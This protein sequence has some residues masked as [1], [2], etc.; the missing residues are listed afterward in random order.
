MRKIAGATGIPTPF[1]KVKDN[2][3]DTFQFETPDD[4][5]S[6]KVPANAANTQPGP[7][8]RKRGN[9]NNNNNDDKRNRKRRKLPKGSCKYCPEATSHY[10]SECYM[11]IREQMGLPNGWQWCLVH[12]KGIHYEHKCRR[13]APDFPPV[14]RITKA[15]FCTPCPDQDLKQR[16]LTMLGISTQ[17]QQPLQQQQPMGR[18][19]IRITPASNNS[20]NFR[21][22]RNVSANVATKGPQ[23][24]QVLSSI[25]QMNETQRQSLLEGLT[26]AGF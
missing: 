8:R 9:N 11:T 7:Q 19:P 25:M 10:T 2:L 13:H 16:V 12:K 6:E 5:K 24:D 17:E 23:V 1:L 21:T 15:A 18:N 20:Q 14:P 3:L 26:N 22:A 4:A